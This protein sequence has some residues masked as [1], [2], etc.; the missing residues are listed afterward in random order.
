MLSILF[1]RHFRKRF[2]STNSETRYLNLPHYYY[3]LVFTVVNNVDGITIFPV[4]L[5]S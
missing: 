5:F 2:A 3:K 4:E 1:S